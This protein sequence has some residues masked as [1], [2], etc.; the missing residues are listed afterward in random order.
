MNIPTFQADH[1]FLPNGT[2]VYVVKTLVYNAFTHN[3]WSYAYINELSTQPPTTDVNN[4]LVFPT[5]DE[6]AQYMKQLVDNSTWMG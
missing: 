1:T 5:A 3:P 2:L 6:A 4:A